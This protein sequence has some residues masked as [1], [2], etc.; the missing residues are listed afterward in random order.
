MRCEDVNEKLPEYMAGVLDKTAADEI[1]KHIDECETCKKSIEE[2]NFKIPKENNIKD[3]ELDKVIKKTQRKFNRSVFKVTLKTVIIL[4]FV[5]YI[6]YSLPNVLLAVQSPKLSVAT[7]ALTDLVQ[8]SQPNMVNSW[9]NGNIDRWKLS[10]PLTNTAIPQIGKKYGM[11][12]DITTDMSILTGKVNAPVFLGADFIHPDVLKDI[13][14][15]NEKNPLIQQKILL[16]NADTTVSTVDFSFNETIPLEGIGNILSQYDVSICWMAVEAGIENITYKNINF[17][18]Q[19]VQQFGIPGKLFL[20]PSLEYVEFKKGNFEKYEEEIKSELKWF[21]ENIDILNY[22]NTN[23]QYINKV[24]GEKD[25]ATAV[26]SKIMKDAVE[27]VLKN[28]FKVYGFRVT[29]PSDQILKL[30]KD[31]NLRAMT[32]IDM[33]FW[34]W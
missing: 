6:I 20:P 21:L 19:Q 18:K 17:D 31:L 30:S 5:L 28:G 9:R 33:D 34:N 7:K 27:Y 4:L 11:Q 12:I 22:K 24:K 13:I 29:G 14:L 26:S 8:F 32:V 16:K 3:I 1:K 10:I 2:L 23:L 25:G 15:D